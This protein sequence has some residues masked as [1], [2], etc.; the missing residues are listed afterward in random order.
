MLTTIQESASA[1]ITSDQSFL[2]SCKGI[3]CKNLKTIL[4]HSFDKKQYVSAILVAS[5]VTKYLF[6]LATF[7]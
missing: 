5:L 1:G 4:K 6:K 7:V 2:A 3:H